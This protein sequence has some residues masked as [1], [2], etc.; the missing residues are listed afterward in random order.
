MGVNRL[1]AYSLK[2][3][4]ALHGYLA[5][6]G[7]NTVNGGDENHGA[8]LAVRLAKATELPSRLQRQ[9]IICD[10]LLYTSRCV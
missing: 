6:A 7:V 9:G 5:D 10:C 2:Q 4:D 3:L 1:R 8:F